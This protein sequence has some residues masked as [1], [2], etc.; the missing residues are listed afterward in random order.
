M[1]G[2]AINR[3]IQ[4]RVQPWPVLQ[5]DIVKK[6]CSR[7]YKRVYNKVWNRAGCKASVQYWN[8]SYNT[9]LVR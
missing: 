4:R 1:N 6:A 3:N 9:A 2:S 5:N 8:A 7:V